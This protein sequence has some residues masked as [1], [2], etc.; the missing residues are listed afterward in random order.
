LDEL[1]TAKAIGKKLREACV[2]RSGPPGDTALPAVRKLL[3]L[4]NYDVNL[5]DANQNGK[6]E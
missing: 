3:S 6:C 5:N 4:P 2:D 1:S